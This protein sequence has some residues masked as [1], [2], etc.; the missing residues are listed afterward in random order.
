MCW[1]AVNVGA[2]W[3]V[4]NLTVAF[5]C[6]RT[7]LVCLLEQ[8]C[9]RDGQ[10]TN[11]SCGTSISVD[12][13]WLSSHTQCLLCSVATTLDSLDLAQ[14]GIGTIGEIND[15]FRGVRCTLEL[16]LALLPRRLGHPSASA[17][18]HRQ[19][20]VR[21]LDR[22]LI[23]WYL[24]GQRLRPIHCHSNALC[25]GHGDETL[26]ARVDLH[27][28]VLL[29]AV[30]ILGAVCRRHYVQTVRE[31]ALLCNGQLVLALARCNLGQFHGNE[32]DVH[33]ARTGLVCTQYSHVR[34]VGRDNELTGCGLC[35][36]TILFG[37]AKRSR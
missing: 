27:R 14:L 37:L 7:G 35:A 36:I 12:V 8:R 31:V 33:D 18:I 20:C 28:K 3:N 16:F 26:A 9:R 10:S 11:L 25:P 34:M 19:R 2:Q 29:N 13:I 21:C 4:R 23:L 1:L 6:A 30:L 24:S 22:W 17:R 15:K 32:A 5:R